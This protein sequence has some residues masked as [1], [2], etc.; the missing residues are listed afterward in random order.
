MKTMTKSFSCV[1]MKNAIQSR[2]VA[3]RRGMSPAQFMADVESTLSQ[4][5]DPI[6]EYWRKLDP[7]KSSHSRGRALADR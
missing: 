1:E 5:K 3:R 4:S 6:G 2:L 7:R